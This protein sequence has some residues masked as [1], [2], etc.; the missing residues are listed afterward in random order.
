MV[1][2]NQFF[3]YQKYR[4]VCGNQFSDINKYDVLPLFSNIKIQCFLYFFGNQ[5]F[6]NNKKYTIALVISL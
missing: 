2:G 1:C 6:Y 3:G 4:M 5:F